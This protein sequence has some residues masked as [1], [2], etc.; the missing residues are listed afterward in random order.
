MIIGKLGLA[1]SCRR[2][3]TKVAKRFAH[4]SASFSICASSPPCQKTTARMMPWA[5]ETIFM[6]FTHEPYNV[7]RWS[8]RPVFC[9]S[10]M[11]LL[12]FAQGMRPTVV[13]GWSDTKE[14]GH[15]QG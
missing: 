1:R 11:L 10:V 4:F 6:R 13:L 2:S 7:L 9:H 5:G 8:A 15:G 12:P 3:A 14:F